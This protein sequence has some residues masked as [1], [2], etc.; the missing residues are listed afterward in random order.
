M[1]NEQ[2]YF[3]RLSLISKIGILCDLGVNFTY[4]YVNIYQ[5]MQEP[6]KQLAKKGNLRYGVNYCQPNLNT[7]K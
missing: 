5:L 7:Q 6:P 3:T 2:T 1:C 4:K